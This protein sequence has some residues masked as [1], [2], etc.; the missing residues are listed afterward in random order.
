ML[1][2][3]IRIS[4]DVTDVVFSAFIFSVLNQHDEIVEFTLRWGIPSLYFVYPTVDVFKSRNLH[5]NALPMLPDARFILKSHVFISS[6]EHSEF[7]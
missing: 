7:Q 1:S 6:S 3:E 4:S 2:L 5:I